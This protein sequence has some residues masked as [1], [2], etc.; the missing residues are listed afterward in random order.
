M[1]KPAAFS[2]YTHNMRLIEDV[3][4]QYK[5]WVNGRKEKKRG[6]GGIVSLY[7]KFSFYV[8]WYTIT[9]KR[10]KFD[11]RFSYMRFKIGFKHS[12]HFQS[13]NSL[14]KRLHR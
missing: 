4:K 1:C 5:R 6:G 11:E 2:F 9:Y 8:V 10:L 12:G 7:S 3:D 13:P 14:I